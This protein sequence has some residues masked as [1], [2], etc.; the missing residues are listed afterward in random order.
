MGTVNTSTMPDVE[1]LQPE[2]IEQAVEPSFRGWTMRNHQCLVYSYLVLLVLAFAMLVVS[3]VTPAWWRYHSNNR[4]SSAAES[5]GVMVTVQQSWGIGMAGIQIQLQYCATDQG[6][7]TSVDQFRFFD[8]SR[9]D[10]ATKWA[11][12]ASGRFQA[13]ARECHDAGTVLFEACLAGM[14]LSS[15]SLGI[16][17]CTRWTHVC[18]KQCVVSFAVLCALAGGSCV[19]VSALRFGSATSKLSK[20]LSIIS[21]DYTA[22]IHGELAPKLAPGYGYVLGVTA[23]A[24]LGV[25][26]LLVVLVCPPKHV[27]AVHELHAEEVQ[28]VYGRCDDHRLGSSVTKGSNAI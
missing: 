20:A 19:L 24:L 25:S 21:A 18:Y 4:A 3:L 2:H 8:D 26:W 23:G 27:G 15:L 5:E 1:S 14:L 11:T 13:D 7:S 28:S 9:N 6:C 12:V 17:L 10:A 16:V 22:L